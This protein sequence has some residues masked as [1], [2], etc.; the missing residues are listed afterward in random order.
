MNQEMIRKYAEATVRIGA[1]VQPGQ[2]VVVY[3]DVES[4]EFVRL[5]AE[6]AYQAGAESVRVEWSDQAL[7]RSEYT[8]RTLE[9]L[10][11]VPAWKEAQL[12][13]M[14]ETIPCRIN[15][16][17]ADPDGLNGIDRQKMQA[18]QQKRYQVTKPYSDALENKEQWT[19]VAVP[20]KKWA[21]KVF[22][23]IPEDEAVE[24][25]WAAICKTV[26]IT[27]ENDPI[28]A[29]NEH[30]ENFRKKCELLNQYRFEKLVYHSQNG[31]DFTA[32]LIPQALW[33]GGGETALSGIYFN[34]NMPTEEV[35]TSPMK[36]KAEGTL[37]ATKPL[38]YQGTLIEDFRITFKDG[39]AVEWQAKTGADAL[40]KMITSDEG[41]AM[42]GELALVP[43]GSP[44]D[45]LNILFYN[46][47]FDENASCHVALGR[48]FS[49]TIEGFESMT[50]EETD[51][52]GINDSMIHVDFM[53]GAP[54]LSIKGYTKDGK[55]IEIFK[56]GKWAI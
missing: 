16:L 38:S 6:E 13:E 8:Y 54:D 20:S 43:C 15:I 33:M 44:I 21:K 31:T 50:K 51:A 26:R 52:L 25:L 49:N 36:G 2:P 11:Q 19:I 24:K 3:A 45:Q 39:K 9:S 56:D 14:T 47:L 28:E 4:V 35:F 55:E 18:V 7:T 53:I 12:K 17:S 22:P 48:G 27:E 5:V 46:T 1:N 42:L 40:E 30:N 32:W 10:S 23:G 34:P 29:W 37:V 41:A